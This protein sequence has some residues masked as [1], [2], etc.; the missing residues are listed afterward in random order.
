MGTWILAV[1]CLTTVYDDSFLTDIEVSFW[2]KYHKIVYSW[3]VYL[4]I[5]FLFTVRSVI[6]YNILAEKFQTLSGGMNLAV[7][8]FP[9]LAVHIK[10]LEPRSETDSLQAVMEISEQTVL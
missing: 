8:N 6:I 2:R 1:I 10:N 4:H 9:T 7:T 3:F 5:F